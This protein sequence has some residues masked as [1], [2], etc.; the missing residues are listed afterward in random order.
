MYRSKTRGEI[1]HFL[2]NF[3]KSQVLECSEKLKNEV[4]SNL[5]GVD[6]WGPESQKV[7]ILPLL[8]TDQQQGGIFHRIELIVQ[9]VISHFLEYTTCF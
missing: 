5:E 8:C 6:F 2:E 4:L 1:F 9:R 3:Q 7:K